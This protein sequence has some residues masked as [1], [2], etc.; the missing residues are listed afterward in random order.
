MKKQQ[1]RDTVMRLFL[2]DKKADF[3]RI[4]KECKTK[5]HLQKGYEVI[6]PPVCYFATYFLFNK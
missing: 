1:T 5:F 3:S 2:H 4:F 6:W